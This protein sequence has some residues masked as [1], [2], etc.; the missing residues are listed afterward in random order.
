MNKG[1]IDEAKAI[2]AE[3]KA[4]LGLAP[5]Y[6]S[7]KQT[8]SELSDAIKRVQKDPKMSADDKRKR[9]DDLYA[10][11]NMIAKRIELA[12]VRKSQ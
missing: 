4:I 11:R 10:K 6:S 2:R 3:S 8:V 5:A 9:I 7:T 12:R 1:D